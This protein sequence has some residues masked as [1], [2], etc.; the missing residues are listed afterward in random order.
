[1]DDRIRT[2][3][4]RAA[5]I[6]SVAVAV[7][8]LTGRIL[9]DRYGWSQ[10]LLWIPT[11]GA[12]LAAGLGMLT[13]E[14]PGRPRALVAWTAGALAVLGYFAFVEHRLL[15]PASDETSGLRLVHCNILPIGHRARRI[16]VETLV[17]L[18][19][20]LTILSSPLSPRRMEEFG[21]Q[22]ASAG[23]PVYL[24]PFMVFSRLPI[25][26]ARHLVASAGIRIALVQ[27][28]SADLGRPLVVYAVDLPSH[29]RR[30]R[31]EIAL[32]ARALLEQSG[33]PAPD[34]VVGDFNMTRASASLA[35]LFPELAHAYDQAGHGYGATF[36][37]AFPLYHL[38]HT[39]LAETVR[40]VDYDLVDPGIGRHRI[41]VVEIAI[42]HK[43]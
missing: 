13:A 6:V 18:D 22:L 38:D 41:Q 32:E 37:R 15:R 5:V 8:W 43:P 31:M 4:R 35:V 1:M 33:A 14:R 34:I 30:P 2:I 20:E 19:G 16:F 28:E 29:P 11:P 10:W 24:W 39:L 40:A 23:E 9:S 12:L 3:L 26:E 27:V 17:A 36:P 42:I 25:V 7:L 21:D